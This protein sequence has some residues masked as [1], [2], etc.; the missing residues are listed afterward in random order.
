MKG[1][2]A[3]WAMAALSVLS[4]AYR[5]TAQDSLYPPRFTKF[6]CP[7]YPQDHVR[8]QGEVLIEISVA[9]SGEPTE[10]R[11]LEGHPMLISATMEAVKQWRF[12]PYRLNGE[13]VDVS[14]RVK[15][16]FVLKPRSGYHCRIKFP[17]A[18]VKILGSANGRR[19]IS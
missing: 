16:I 2:P 17:P 19:R 3:I 9:K 15:V 4:L 10:I 12:Q 1:L 7:N 8:I 11:A 13:A 18:A 14:M 6:V 5:S